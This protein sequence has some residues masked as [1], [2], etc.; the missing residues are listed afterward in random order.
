MPENMTSQE[1]NTGGTTVAALTPNM[2]PPTQETPTR[3]AKQPKPADTTTVKPKKVR[4]PRVVARPIFEIMD[5]AP[6]KLTE[7][8]KVAL[9]EHLKGELAVFVQ[10]NAALDQNCKSAYEQIRTMKTEIEEYVIKQQTRK[11][12]L[13]QAVNTFNQTMTL[14]LEG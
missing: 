7:G 9:I 1:N 6:A 3:R 12:F 11:A 2:T 4:V 5:I 13:K 8:E 10:Q 14:A